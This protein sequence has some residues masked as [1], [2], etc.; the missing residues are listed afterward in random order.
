MK[1]CKLCR[2]QTHT[3]TSLEKGEDW[4]RF[5]IKVYLPLKDGWFERVRL[6]V[7][8][9]DSFDWNGM[10]YEIQHKENDEEY[11]IFET[12]IT[13][14]T[15]ALYYYYISYECN[16]NYTLLKREVITEGTSIT[17]QECFKLSVNFH[18]PD[19]AKGGIMY[20]ILPDRFCR[21]PS[22]VI[23]EIPGRKLLKDWYGKV[24][25][26]PDEKGDWNTEFYGGNLL[27]IVDK[28]DYIKT[29]GVNILYLNPICYGQSNHLYDTVDY[30]KVDPF[31]GT[32][33]HLKKLCE[34]AH[35][36]G[37]HIILDG[38]YN[39]T[40]NRSIYFDQFG[41]HGTKGVYL[42][43]NSPY[44]NFYRKTWSNGTEY[45]NFWWGQRNLPA[46]D[47]LSEDWIA[48][49]TGEGGIIDQW[50]A[51]GI[52][53]IRLDVA[54]ELSDLL[55]ERILLAI[56]R[57]KPD[58]FLL[59]EQWDNP[60][61]RTR[62]FLKSGKGMH[63]VMNYRLIDPLIGYYNYQNTEKLREILNEILTE[64]PK[65]TIDTLMNPTST[66]DISRAIELFA[67]N[68]F[69]PRKGY[70]WDLD[71]ANDSTFVKEH[72][73]TQEE[74]EFGKK[75]LKSYLVS[76][77]FLPG[78]FSIFYGDEAGVQGLHNQANR[79]SFPWGRED[80]ELQAYF[81]RMLSVRTQ[82]EFLRT[83]TCKVREISK[84]HLVYERISQQEAILVI[85]SR[86]HYETLLH[87][88]TEYQDAEILFCI[89]EQP[90]RKTLMPYGAIIFK[91]RQS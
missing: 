85:A 78:I 69:N 56:K 75:K 61:R 84:E 59:G 23:P 6:H 42:N 46:C 12:E 36:R 66:H 26:G 31:F 18:A 71:Y 3:I 87:I 17:K 27:G 19:W 16:G 9:S 70:C 68:S 86:T 80:Q 35:K 37:M 40:G 45:Y 22:V 64:Y 73:L 91:K 28:L 83:A 48:Y 77:A 34:E 76:L 8:T 52:D 67:T 11:A 24:P 33:E 50:F 82:N 49:I 38:V 60:M 25:V 5:K 20:Q 53:G 90:D 63:S 58:G 65:D 21:N 51:C 41:E 44:R 89:E 62:G 55:I 72:R 29:F 88:P 1:M 15:S 54:D 32:K 30:T 79:T 57:N 39:H 74:Y 14:T 2:K 7:L 81:R 43:P 47:T 10:E 4:E 13:L